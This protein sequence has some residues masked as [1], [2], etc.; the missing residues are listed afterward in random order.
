ME[1][2]FEDE[3]PQELVVKRFG[4]SVYSSVLMLLLIG[5]GPLV[6]GYF[7]I[8]EFL[9]LHWLVKIPVVFII[10]IVVLIW[11]LMVNCYFHS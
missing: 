5:V 10:L 7:F 9:D 3:I 4:Y 1:F 8:G 2:L 6:G 11:V